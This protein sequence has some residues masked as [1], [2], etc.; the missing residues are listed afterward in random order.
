[1]IWLTWRQ[2][3]A[4]AY[5]G[6]AFL[7]VGS[8]ALV[9]Y[10]LD[11][12]SAYH[13]DGINACVIS[14]TRGCDQAIADFKQQFQ[15][16]SED[17]L[18]YL[19]LLV[20]LV[21]AVVGG[22]LIAREDEQGTWRLAWTQ[23]VPRTRWLLVKVALTLTGL[24]LFSVCMSLVITWFRTPLDHVS[25]RMNSPA[26]DFE[27]L[28]LV[29]YTVCAFGVGVLAGLVTRRAVTAIVASY[30]VFLAIRIP[31]E[32]AVRRDYQRPLTRVV[33]LDRNASP[34]LKLTDWDLGEGWMDAAGHRLSRA[35][36][37]TLANAA[38]GVRDRD[39]LTF[40]QAHHISSWVQYQPVSRFWTF[41]AI[42]FGIFAG[43]GLLALAVAGWR[44]YR[45]GL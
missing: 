5:W 1:M 45:R 13:T 23:A 22:P 32:F 7:A 25:S 2:H 34:L 36:M 17:L 35:Q 6:L 15:T 16:V 41:Q 21:G 31:L 44:L 29:G 24:V 9:L 19:S 27:G 8:I 28:S 10:G 4:Q 37:N 38:G 20:G 30:V 33:P 11:I 26:F 12:R 3:R 14:N 42:E 40:L 18:P 39:S 43:V